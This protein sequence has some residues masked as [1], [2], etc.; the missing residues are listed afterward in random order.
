MH[1]DGIPNG[2]T[3]SEG[4]VPV[5]GGKLVYR[6]VGQGPVLVLIHGFSDDGTCWPRLVRD[7][8]SEYTLILP[9][10]RGHGRSARVTP[11]QA[12]DL[13]EDLI[14]LITALALERPVLLGH[15]MGA[16]LAAEVA[17]RMPQVVR[18]LILEDPPWRDGA[19][20]AA[21]EQAAREHYREWIA[22]AQSQSLEALI[23][24][25]RAQH[26]GWDESEFRPWAESK[27]RLDPHFL[28]MPMPW[29]RPWR[30]TA[31]K[32]TCPLLLITGEVAAGA[33]VTPEVAQEVLHLLPQAEVVALR[34]AG[35]S[36]RREAYPDYLLSMRDFLGRLPR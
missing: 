14:T 28:D 16:S 2:I 9:D 30:E 7:L 22:F 11:G 32:V 5:P 8:A 17:A 18:A 23:A 35:H 19:E 13:A 24:Q 6:Q 36:V 3:M 25:V 26:P 20:L 33:I 27:H 1:V 12:F 34:G 29:W 21:Q 10:V 15:S 31:L 4:Q